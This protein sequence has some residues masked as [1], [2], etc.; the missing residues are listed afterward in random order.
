[1]RTSRI[2]TPRR[3][4]RQGRTRANA[5]KRLLA[6]LRL[7]GFPFCPLPRVQIRTPMNGSASKE[8]YIF[9]RFHAREGMEENVATAMREMLPPVRNEAGCISIAVFRSTRDGRL[10]YVHSH[11]V[12]EAAFELHATLPHTRHFIETIQT[13]I[14]HP[15]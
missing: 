5:R 15:L 3:Q 6:S 9:A 2:E 10:F 14:D 4:G 12:D 13:L 7:G 8:L 11:W 1:M